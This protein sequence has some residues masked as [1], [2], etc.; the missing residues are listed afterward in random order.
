[1]YVV[2]EME[3]VMNAYQSALNRRAPE[4]N[5][6][7]METLAIAIGSTLDGMPPEFFDEIVSLARK[8]GADRLAEFHGR[9]VGLV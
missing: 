6:L 1:M 5:A 9:E 7:H 3:D 4:M 8:M 2:T